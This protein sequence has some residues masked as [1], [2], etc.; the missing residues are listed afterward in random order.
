MYYYKQVKNDNIVSIEAK[1]IDAASPNFVK[2]T[3][4]EYDD[5]MASLPVVEPEPPRST[6]ISV[7][8]VIDTS[9]TRPVRVKRVWEGKDYFYDCLV[10]E[11]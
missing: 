11:S 6:H 10:T 7:I 8:E 5:F 9:K 2:A 1:S 4:A 3:K